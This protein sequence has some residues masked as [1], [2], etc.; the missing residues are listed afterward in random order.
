MAS[1]ISETFCPLWFAFVPAMIIASDTGRFIAVI[2]ALDITIHS[3]FAIGKSPLKWSSTSPVPGTEAHI[4]LA[5]RS[6]M[7]NESGFC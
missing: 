6:T 1:K 3:C 5:T 2:A 4:A 7:L